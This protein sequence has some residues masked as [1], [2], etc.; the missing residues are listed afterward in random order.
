MS[1]YYQWA[2]FRLKYAYSLYTRHVHQTSAHQF[3]F[4]DPLENFLPLYAKRKSCDF[5]F[6]IGCDLSGSPQRIRFGESPTSADVPVFR[7]TETMKARS[8]C[9]CLV[10]RFQ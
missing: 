6:F 1:V 4:T 3:F 9:V 8:S 7:E 2:I 5:E 10:T